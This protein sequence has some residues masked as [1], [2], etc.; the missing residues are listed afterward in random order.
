MIDNLLITVQNFV[1]QMLTSISGDE[2]IDEYIV[3]CKLVC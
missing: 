2:Y 1:M 3:V